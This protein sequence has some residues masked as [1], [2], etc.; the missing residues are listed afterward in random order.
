MPPGELEQIW[1]ELRSLRQSVDNHMKG[2]AE[3]TASHGERLTSVES[4][5]EHT[6]RERDCIVMHSQLKSK[7]MHHSTNWEKTWDVLKIV[8]AAGFGAAIPDLLQKLFS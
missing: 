3:V 1:R 2:I 6:V 8:L 7:L 4:D 5:L